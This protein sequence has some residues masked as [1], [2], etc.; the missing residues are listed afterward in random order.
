M[1]RISIADVQQLNVK[2]RFACPQ[3]LFI[4]DIHSGGPYPGAEP[5]KISEYDSLILQI[6][7]PLSQLESLNTASQLPPEISSLPVLTYI[8]GGGFI[9]GKIDAHHNPAYLT[10]HSIATSQPLI[11]TSIQYRVGALGF[12][13]SP[14][15]G[16]NFGLYD[17]RNALLWIRRFIE[18]FGGDNNRMTVFGESAGGYSICLHM[19]GHQP[20]E[21]PLFHRAIIM[22]GIL[23]PI[24]APQPED[25]AR[26]VLDKILG[27]LDIKERGDAALEK[28]QSL[29]VQ[30]LVDASDSWIGK[31]N[32]WP[33]IEDSNW[34]R[35]KVTW[36]KVPEFLGKCE[37]VDELVIGNTGFEGAAFPSVANDVTPQI[38]HDH[39]ARQMS[40][41]AA[42]KTMDAYAMT[43][44]MDQN[45]FLTPAMRWCG[46]V[47]FDSKWLSLSLCCLCSFTDLG[48]P[49]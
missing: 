10:Q 11:T 42:K 28:L 15:G 29:D 33:P 12:M 31:G 30:K 46:D 39:I 35:E 34:F 45:K 23:G 22:S 47:C 19:L 7:V 49:M 43:L 2:H 41:E 18:G 36:D 1:T 26:E 6:N 25:E 21:G 24:V 38:F 40:L 8:H 44:D 27:G 4:D 20:Q 9:I 32:T 5:T 37:W 3:T 13:A 17:Q 48:A 14:D 16:K